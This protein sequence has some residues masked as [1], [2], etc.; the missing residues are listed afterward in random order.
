MLKFIIISAIVMAALALGGCGDDDGNGDNGNDPQ[1]TGAD[2]GNS[3]SPSG[4]G[5]ESVEGINAHAPADGIPPLDDSLEVQTT[6]GGL[7]YID[8]VVGDGA[9]IE[10]GQV[11]TVHYTGW[12]TDGTMFDTSRDPGG[13]AFQFPVGAGRVIAGWDEGVGSMNVGGKRR[14]IIP[15]DLGYG[16]RGSTSGSIPP[17]AVLIFDVEVLAAQ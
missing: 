7:R 2:A 17:G 14:L 4:T 1:A 16:D 15:A 12:L 10:D 6:D 5:G 8:E 11:A 9:E 13:A 3:S